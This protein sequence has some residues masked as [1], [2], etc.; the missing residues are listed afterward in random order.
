MNALAHVGPELLLGDVDL[1]VPGSEAHDVSASILAISLQD[2]LLSLAIFFCHL[3]SLDETRQEVHAMHHG[4][5]RQVLGQLDHV[6]D[7]HTFE[8]TVNAASGNY[9]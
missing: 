1:G 4:V 2:A 7:L 8:L 3:G 5:L 6:L 9:C